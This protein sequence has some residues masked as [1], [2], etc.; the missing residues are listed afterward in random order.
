MSF[1]STQRQ[2]I[3]SF[4]LTIYL[5]IVFSEDWYAQNSRVP[6]KQQTNKR[7]FATIQDVSFDDY[8]NLKQINNVGNSKSNF[9]L[10]RKARDLQDLIA[11]TTKAIPNVRLVAK[12]MSTSA[13]QIGFDRM[14]KMVK[15]QQQ[16][17]QQQ[18]QQF[19]VKP[20]PLSNLIKNP[21][22]LNM[23]NSISGLQQ[24]PSLYNFNYQQ[25]PGYDTAQIYP[26]YNMYGAIPYPLYENSYFPQYQVTKRMFFPYSTSYSDSS[27]TSPPH[28]QYPFS[29]AYARAYITNMEQQ[30]AVLDQSSPIPSNLQDIPSMGTSLGISQG[31]IDL[32]NDVNGF[33]QAIQYMK[34]AFISQDTEGDTSLSEKLN[35]P[36]ETVGVK[37]DLVTKQKKSSAQLIDAYKKTLESKNRLEDK[38]VNY[39]TNYVCGDDC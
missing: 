37:K 2:Y 39:F 13:A 18:L 32:E 20:I 35:S 21:S 36:K 27:T 15:R 5:S 6:L 26:Q 10:H 1:I 29:N 17:Q 11:K 33:N 23:Q 3:I 31:L 9:M 14:R 12:S 24:A 22:D 16:Q 8:S 4:F 38:L 19:A 25:Y 28:F 7:S 30:G 34:E